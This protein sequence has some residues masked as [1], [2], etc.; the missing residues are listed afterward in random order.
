[1][2]GQ[3]TWDYYSG[4]YEATLTPRASEQLKVD[5]EEH[6]TARR[7]RKLSLQTRRVI[8]YSTAARSTHSTAA[9]FK[10]V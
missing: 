2:S 7:T 9:R 3:V 1:M 8:N 6:G 5:D 4:S 10:G